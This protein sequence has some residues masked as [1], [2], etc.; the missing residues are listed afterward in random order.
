MDT[1]KRRWNA[2]PEKKSSVMISL[3][4]SSSASKDDILFSVKNM[5]SFLGIKHARVALIFGAI[6]LVM[7][8]LYISFSRNSESS[9]EFVNANSKCPK[10]SYRPRDEINVRPINFELTSQV[11]IRNN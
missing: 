2:Y 9:S 3:P 11:S 5:P 4:T 8:C 10:L 6:I 7:T 1:K